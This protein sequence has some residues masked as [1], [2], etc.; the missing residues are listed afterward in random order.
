LSNLDINAC[1]ALTAVF[2]VLGT[3]LNIQREIV[4]HITE[5][6]IR[7]NMTI[8]ELLGEEPLKIIMDTDDL[9]RNQKVKKVRDYL[10][11]KR[12]PH[13][14]RAEKDFAKNV[15]RLSLGGN[16]RLIAPKNFESRIFTLKLS[17]KTLSDLKKHL[18]KMEEMIQHP[19][20]HNILA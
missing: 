4:S 13:I 10:F 9:D 3:G 11:K 1:R 12:F 8:P 14:H 2:V 5:I 17:F 16:A 19:V 7:D 6:G 15:K 20:M 18:G